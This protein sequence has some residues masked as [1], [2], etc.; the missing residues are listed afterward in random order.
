MRCGGAMRGLLEKVATLAA[1]RDQHRPSAQADS[2]KFSAS[3]CFVV[4]MDQ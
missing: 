4:D 3:A 2:T 1:P